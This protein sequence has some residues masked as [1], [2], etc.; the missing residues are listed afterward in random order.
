ME[1]RSTKRILALKK[2]NVVQD[3]QLVEIRREINVM[4]KCASP[5]VVKSYGSQ[6]K[7]NV[8]WVSSEADSF[9]LFED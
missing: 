1:H 9:V 7:D 8:M 3:S 5:H 4:K 2:I 6:F